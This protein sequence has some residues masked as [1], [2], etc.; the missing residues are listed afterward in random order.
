M[1]VRLFL[2]GGAVRDLLL[3][4]P[5]LD[6]DL[7]LEGDAIAFARRLA[8][9]LRVH[10]RVHERFRTVTLELADGHRLDVA[11]SRRETYERPAALPRV[12]PAPI[13]VDLARRDFA[14]NAMALEIAPGR[15]FRLLDP[16]GGLLDLRRRQ[17]RM[18]H[19]NSPLDD[20][21]RAFRAVRY[22]NRLGFQ[23]ESG[24]RRS[25]L[26]AVRRN[27]FDAVSGDRLCRE[28]RWLFSE[29]RRAEVVRWIKRLDLS[30]TLH[31]ALPADAAILAK[32]RRAERIARRHPG[33]TTWFQYLLVWA[34]RLDTGEAEA[35]SK[36][37]SLG[38]QP[39]RI[40]RSWPQTLNR[41]RE[42]GPTNSRVRSLGL[43]ADELAAAAAVLPS[44]VARKRLEL[45]L[46]APPV[47]LTIRG[48]DLV[49]AGVPPGPAIGRALAETLSALE[50]GMIS[51]KEQLD[52]ALKAARKDLS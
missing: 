26:E 24:T 52:F 13:E 36:R 25:I 29:E 43:S 5:V 1:R 9:R 42:A 48:S 4:R 6:I 18:L 27:V 8:A 45:A 44:A 34:A 37:L 21:T 28:I 41:L 15:R 33:R 14:I 19:E 3:R 32:L 38:R 49:A 23:I 16:F 31:A 17:I 2:A 50:D 35:L 39:A 22:A 11:M 10:A 7:V 12:E 20:P 40:L 30:G 47:R 46:S 51:S